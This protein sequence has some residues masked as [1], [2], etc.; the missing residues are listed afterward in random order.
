L[1]AQKTPEVPSAQ[2]VHEDKEMG[3]LLKTPS[4]TDDE[5]E[6]TRS[7]ESPLRHCLLHLPPRD[8]ESFLKNLG[9]HE[10][11]GNAVL[12]EENGTETA[13]RELAVNLEIG[14]PTARTIS[15]GFLPPL[16][17]LGLDTYKPVWGPREEVIRTLKARSPGRART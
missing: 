15:S 5:G 2:K 3:F 7:K 10:F 12:E 9:C 1:S 16:F 4:E 6:A 17:E 13:R 8:H 11:P 14:Y